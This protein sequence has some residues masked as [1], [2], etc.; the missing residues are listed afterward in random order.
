MA[1]VLKLHSCEIQYK[2]KKMYKIHRNMSH[3]CGIYEA[4]IMHKKLVR[5]ICKAQDV[6]ECQIFR[7]NISRVKSLII[8]PSL[9]RYICAVSNVGQSIQ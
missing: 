5:D 9:M 1:K 6:H 8:F 7:K 4:K 3:V 2:L